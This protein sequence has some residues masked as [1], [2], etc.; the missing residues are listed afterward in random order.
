MFHDYSL[1]R[2]REEESLIRQMRLDS[3]RDCANQKQ[4]KWTDKSISKLLVLYGDGLDGHAIAKKL[5]MS[6]A[7]VTHKLHR[8]GLY[9]KARSI[10]AALLLC[11]TGAPALA[12]DDL[13]LQGKRQVNLNRPVTV[14][15]VDEL[16]SVC[17]GG[18]DEYA[19]ASAAYKAGRCIVWV[20]P[21]KLEYVFH[22]LQH[23]AGVTHSA[24]GD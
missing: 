12:N 16:P 3:R 21:N 5:G 2:Q 23:C 15:V 19:C 6:Y 7:R 22:E 1:T 9:L 8:M 20:K 11:L 24:K 10:A 4:T 13:M 18:G 14:I 17:G